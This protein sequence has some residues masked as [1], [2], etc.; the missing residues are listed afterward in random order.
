MISALLLLVTSVLEANG[1]PQLRDGAYHVQP[2]QDIQAALGLAAANSKH[3]RVVVHTGTYR[4]SSKR[5]AL[6][7]FNAKHNGV[8]LQADGHVG[9]RPL[10]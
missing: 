2:G 10:K 5:Q 3:K 4:P 8:T 6:I 9:Y 1:A 7:W